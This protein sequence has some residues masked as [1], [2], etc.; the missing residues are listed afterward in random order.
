[1]SDL[2]PATLMAEHQ[3]L[4][5]DDQTCEVSS[6]REPWPC[7]TYRMAVKLSAE[8]AKVQWVREL[9]DA[10]DLGAPYNPMLAGLAEVLRFAVRD[11]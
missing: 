2:D 3:P 10:Y 6:C 11:K 9:A 7:L 4:E 5:P 8:Q 1:M